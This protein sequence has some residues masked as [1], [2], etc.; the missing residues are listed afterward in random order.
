MTVDE[1]RARLY[2]LRIEYYDQRKIRKQLEKDIN[3][4]DEI[5]ER[6]FDAHWNLIDDCYVQ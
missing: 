2:E 4:L 1:L 3:S 5:M 6:N